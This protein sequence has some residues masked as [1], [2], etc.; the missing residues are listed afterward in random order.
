MERTARRGFSFFCQE[1][2]RYCDLGRDDIFEDRGQKVA[3]CPAC[4]RLLVLKF[5]PI[6]HRNG[7]N[8]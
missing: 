7:G 2:K 3:V 4:K 1:R 5:T 6:E 8:E